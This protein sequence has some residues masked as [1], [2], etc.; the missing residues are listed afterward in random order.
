MKQPDSDC[1]LKCT[2]D[3]TA[4]C[5]GSHSYMSSYITDDSSKSKLIA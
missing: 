2:G 3:N 4:I 1:T 5:G